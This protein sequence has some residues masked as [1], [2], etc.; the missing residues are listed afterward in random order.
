MQQY[1]CTVSFTGS[2]DLHSLDAGY[3][4]I[5]EP[6]YAHAVLITDVVLDNC[7]VASKQR[8]CYGAMSRSNHL[9]IQRL[10]WLKAF[11]MHACHVF[12][13]PP[14]RRLPYCLYQLSSPATRSVT[15]LRL[16]LL[17]IMEHND[18]HPL[19]SP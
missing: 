4:V 5:T 2:P 11:G 3:D 19:K 1:K 9:I 16:L 13:F 8:N 12:R 18:A 10:T 14:L 6:I 7:C 15:C 17:L